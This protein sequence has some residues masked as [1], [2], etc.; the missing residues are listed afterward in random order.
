MEL[1]EVP[2]P[3]ETG[4]LLPPRQLHCRYWGG[5]F[6]TNPAPCGGSD[7]VSWQRFASRRCEAE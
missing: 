5:E 4:D 3:G 1:E 6:L 2:E 7:N